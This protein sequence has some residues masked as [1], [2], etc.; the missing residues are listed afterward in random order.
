MKDIVKKT[1]HLSLILG[2]RFIGLFIVMSVLSA[3]ATS[4]E[5]LFCYSCRTSCW[6]DHAANTSYLSSSLWNL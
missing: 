5:Q 6:Q 1:W 3:Y 4:L 2:L